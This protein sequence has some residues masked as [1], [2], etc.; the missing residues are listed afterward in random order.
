M[1]VL[2]IIAVIAAILFPVVMGAKHRAKAA[3]ALSNMRQAYDAMVIYLGDSDFSQLPAGAEA[4]A[5]FR[6][7]PMVDPLD[8]LPSHRWDQAPKP[9]IGSFA[10]PRFCPPWDQAKPWE[11]YLRADHPSLLMSVFSSSNRLNFVVNA[12]GMLEVPGGEM[13]DRITKL[14][15]DGSAKNKAVEGA[16]SPGGVYA[17]FNWGGLLEHG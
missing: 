6:G 17:L 4:Y 7:A 11:S 3:V 1:V 10:Y 13:P 8:Y 16:G 2:A 5:V 12:D 14:Y 15:T 9:L